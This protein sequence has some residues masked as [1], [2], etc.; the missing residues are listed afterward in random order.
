M[1]KISMLIAA[2]ATLIAG[3]Q[4]AEAGL[5][6]MPMALRSAIQQIEFETPTLLPTACTGFCQRYE[7]ECQPRSK[8][9]FRGG[10]VWVELI[11]V[12]QQATASVCPG[13]ERTVRAPAQP[14]RRVPGDHP[15]G[16]ALEGHC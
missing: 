15:W 4:R 16:A 3:F 10:P 6:G 13:T 7:D 8:L 5:L 14:W 9:S 1:R 11:E 12:N 2:T